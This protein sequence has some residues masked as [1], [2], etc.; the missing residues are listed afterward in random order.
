MRPEVP[1]CPAAALLERARAAGA[2]LT[3]AESCTGGLLAAELTEVP[4]ASDVFLQ[5]IVSYSNTA[6]QQLLGVRPQTLAAHGA[7]SEPVA[8][9]MA[10]GA[11]RAASAT[12]AISITGIAGP[13]GSDF[14][15]EGRVCFGLATPNGA[16][17]ETIE[18]GALGRGAVRQASVTH[19][20][21]LLS[22]ALDQLDTP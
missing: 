15:P 6:K 8:R 22:G 20:L 10:T 2:T 14:K 16:S 19:A 18:F 4:G 9:E 5:G 1:P 12:L 21:K 7:V 17:A 11:R 13:G 3:T